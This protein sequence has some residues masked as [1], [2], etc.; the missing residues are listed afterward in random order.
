[1]AQERLPMRKIKK[2]LEFHFEEGRSARAIATHCGLARRSVSQ[3][4][5]RFATSGLTWPQARDMDDTVLE[6]RLY[7]T[8]RALDWPEVDWAK[9]EKDL[10]G[11]GVTLMLV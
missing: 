5:E 7:R 8:P 11:R 2:V 3:T 1:M 4:L 10:S 9:V 6:A